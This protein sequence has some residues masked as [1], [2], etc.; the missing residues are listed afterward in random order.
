MLLFDLLI[1][2]PG[3]IVAAWFQKPKPPV[4][5]GSHFSKKELAGKGKANALAEGKAG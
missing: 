3:Q 2:A 1:I 5:G 4:S